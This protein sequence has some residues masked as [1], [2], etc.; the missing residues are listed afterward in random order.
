MT[1]SL[2]AAVSDN[3]VIGTGNRLPWRLPADMSYFKERTEGHHVLTG[4]K[5]Y[6]TIPPKFRP[7]PNRKNIVVTRQNAIENT[8]GQSPVLSH[9]TQLY[10]VHSIKEGI[11]LA[12]KNGETELFVIGGGEIYRQTIDLADRL[13]ITWVH[14]ILQGDT[15]FPVINFKIWKEIWRNDC[16]ANAKNPFDYSFCSYSR[17]H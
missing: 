6:F 1:I 9:P 8:V 2:I 5:N 14:T 15:F 17:A 16:K 12:E 3:Y 13:Y 10:T 7:L 4:R 11:L